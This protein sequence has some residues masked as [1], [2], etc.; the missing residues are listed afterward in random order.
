[1]AHRASLKDATSMRSP[2]LLWLLSIVAVLRMTQFPP[3]INFILNRI[4][5]YL[6]A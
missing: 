5:I 6:Q 1:M 2:R 3:A 4:V